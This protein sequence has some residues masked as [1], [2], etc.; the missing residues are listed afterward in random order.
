MR[1]LKEGW[2]EI[3]EVMFGGLCATIGL[4]PHT[5]HVLLQQLSLLFISL[6]SLILELCIITGPPTHSVEWQD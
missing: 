5:L 2:S 1:L 3:P 6:A 4:L